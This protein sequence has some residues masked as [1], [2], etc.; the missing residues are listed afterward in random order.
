LLARKGD[1][2]PER[3]ERAY[4]LTLGRLPTGREVRRANTFLSEYEAEYREQPPP[5]EPVKP[6]PKPKVEKPKPANPD[7]A[8][9]TGEPVS[10]DLVRPKDARSAA[11]LAFVQALYGCAEFRHVK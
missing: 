7:E 2:D 3:I 1:S 8:D 11:W 4:R 9:Q 5:P 10:E 6:R